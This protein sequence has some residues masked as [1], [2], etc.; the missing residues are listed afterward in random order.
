MG[1][2]LKGLNLGYFGMDYNMMVFPHPDYDLGP[3]RREGM[4]TWYQCPAL[5]YI[6]E[7]PDGLILWETG[8]SANWKMDWPEG[9]QSVVDLSTITPE[10][11]LEAR[12]K[13]VGLGP[14]DFKYVVMGH[15]HADHTGGLSLFEKSG[16][17]VV[18][19]EDEYAY[20]STIEKADNFF[21]RSEWNFL[22][23]NRP[24]TVHGDQEILKGVKLVSLPG[25]TPGTMGMLV[26]LDHTGWVLLTSD[27]L[28]THD[29]YGPPPIPGASVSIWRPDEWFR[30]VE[31]LRR[32]ATEHDAFVMPGHGET[33]IQHREGKT[34]LRTIQ[35]LPAHVYE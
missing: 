22:G 1:I 19:H 10:V 14:E 30:S 9:W 24:V 34:A 16:T 29:S 11:C 28:Y 3:N 27:A 4:K 15:L 25:H 32:I 20:A 8:V 21:L 13:E 6:I 31:R 5:A 7:H 35:Y 23:W 26:K 17:T 2:K 18:V 12:L 33:G